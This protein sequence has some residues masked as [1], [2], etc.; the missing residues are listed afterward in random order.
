M[1]TDYELRKKH[2]RRKWIIASLFGGWT[3]G[4]MITLGGF[5]YPIINTPSQPNGLERYEEIRRELENPE[6]I[7]QVN[8]LETELSEIE[9]SP[10]FAQ[11]ERY[12]RER[13]NNKNTGYYIS[14]GGAGLALLSLMSG[15]LSKRKSR[16]RKIIGT[17]PQKYKDR[18]IS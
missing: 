17:Q 16:K 11:I 7:A 2:S 4:I 1:E 9:I 5:M 18:Q 12:E 13:Q 8:K 6:Q 10:N 3:A 14:S 15:F